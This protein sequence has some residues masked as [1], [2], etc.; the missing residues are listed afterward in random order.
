MFHSLLFLHLEDKE[1]NRD[2][3]SAQ[4]TS[5][6]E[7]LKSTFPHKMMPFQGAHPHLV[8]FSPAGHATEVWEQKE[9][10]QC[11]DIMSV[12]DCSFLARIL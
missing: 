10:E 6:R 7:L 4:W 9:R 5:Y 3:C 12:M 11:M 1:L 2:T 8:R